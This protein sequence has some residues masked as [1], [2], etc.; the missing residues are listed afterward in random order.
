[1]NPLKAVELPLRGTLLVEASAGTGKTQ[2]ITT[3]F[4]RLVVEEGL[5]VPQIVVVTFTEA[6][7]AELRGRIRRRLREALDAFED[8]ARARD[9]DLRALVGAGP[10]R[11]LGRRRLERALSE[12]DLASVSTIHAFCMRVLQEHA[13]ESGA[14][15][16]LELLA[17]ASE[18][19]REVTEDFWSSRMVP[20]APDLY[21]LIPGSFDL[22][23]ARK[24]VDTFARLPADLPVLPGTPA[25]D[26][27]MARARLGVGYSA[28]RTE[29]RTHGAAIRDLVTRADLKRT[30]YTSENI[31]RWCADLDDLFDDETP[32]FCVSEALAQ[33]GE[34]AIQGAVKVRKTPPRHRFFGLAQTLVEINRDAQPDLILG[35]KRGAVAFVRREM[36]LRKAARGVHGFEDLLFSVDRV[37]A[38]PG[39]EALA[40]VLREQFRAVLIDEF[41]DTDPVQFRIFRTLFHGHRSL[42]I[43]GDPKQSI[44]AFRGA[45][46]FSYFAAVRDAE[47]AC[48]TLATNYRSDPSLVR[49]VNTLFGNA[50]SPA[51]VFPQIAFHPVEPKARRDRIAL[52]P[53]AGAF[54]IL[55][56]PREEGARPHA[57]GQLNKDLPSLVAAEIARF[58]A[59]GVAIEDQRVGAGHVAVLTRTNEQAREM[60]NALRRI[61]IPTALQSEASVFESAEATEVEQ[62]LRA[63]LE[64]TRTPL[65]K[66]ALATSILGLAADEIVALEDDEGAWQRW[67]DRLRGVAE[68]WERLGFIQA[69]RGMLT[70]LGVEQRLLSYVDGE[71]RMTNLL[72]LGELLHRAALRERL[73]MTGLVR[74]LGAMRAEPWENGRLG[75]EASELRLESDARATKI[76][77]VHR[78]KGLEYPVVYCPF[79][80]ALGVRQTDACLAFHDPSDG[81]R[82][83]IHLEP[84]SDQAA[85]DAAEVEG[86]AENQRLLYVALTRAKHRCSIVW[87]AI[88][89]T[90]GSPLA[91]TLHPHRED[92]SRASDTELREDLARLTT[93]SGGAIALRDLVPGP[94]P[95]Y[96]PEDRSSGALAARVFDRTIDRSWRIGSFSALTSG[97]RATAPEAGGRDRDEVEDR[98]EI[99]K[100]AEASAEPVI[101]DAFPR[102]TKAGLL[103]HSLLEDH[104]FA[105]RDRAVLET[106]VRQKLASYGYAKEGL[107]AMLVAGID[108]ML[109][110]PL[111][112]T[113]LALRS[114]TRARRLDELEFVLPVA[115]GD[116]AS[117][118]GANTIADAFAKHA[119][120]GIPAA[121]VERLRGLGF[122]A[123]RGF[124][125]GFVD[126]VFEHA[127][128]FYVVDYKS[129]HL[130]ATPGDY[131]RARL[132]PA[133]AHADYYLQYH[134]YVV[135]VDR[136]LRR[137]S[138]GYDYET[139]FGGVLYLF[140]RGMS[141]S[142]APGTGVFSDRPRGALVQALSEVLDG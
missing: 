34:V 64:P 50:R 4:V 51:F 14:R 101:L 27:E 111:D 54:E 133:M 10:D 5:S 99:A 139:G 52:A 28:A 127:G 96:V 32:S 13:F 57:K 8:P 49:A 35:L 75:N 3:L 68:D 62:V 105:C 23:Q 78:S 45:D 33:L 20:M 97:E 81:H 117:R 42:I 39:G 126:L 69:Y 113:G 85:R 136:W 128:R 119:G 123:L 67:S 91:V 120:P 100:A 141:P 65:F 131:T 17:D 11:A 1:V 93:S 98:A 76:L 86:R 104:D 24:L 124:L 60:Q 9:E 73:G 121:Y 137:R 29:W 132:V 109:D 26:P 31:E 48:Y 56:L 103:I 80:W 106:L 7:T 36:P 89:D 84:A 44:Y 114:V 116:G 2:T 21:R 125:R 87:G 142:H 107:G 118:L 41:Q 77:T 25:R 112:P 71:R 15:F 63:V 19:A 47:G 58:L 95:V 94:A 122:P 110:T 18:L 92:P 83:K 70:G 115:H 140:A 138:A 46:V 82:L 108:A 90:E 135:A 129:N 134:L 61:G 6:A 102:G 74:W 53:G 130:G 16:G 79:L 88:N 37:L 12:L 40:R 55:F 30:R 66:T 38:S 72:H 59:S 43:V 22:A